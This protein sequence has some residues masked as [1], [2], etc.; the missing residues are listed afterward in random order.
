ME[1][2]SVID[3]GND[4]VRKIFRSKRAAQIAGH[5]NADLNGGK[6]ARRLLHQLQKPGRALIAF[7]R[8]SA[9]LCRA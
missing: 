8:H 3:P 4:I 9:K 7:L 1:P 6:K 5:G 2:Q